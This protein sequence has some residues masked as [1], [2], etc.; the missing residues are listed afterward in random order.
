MKKLCFSILAVLFVLPT[1]FLLA[2]TLVRADSMDGMTID[3]ADVP[4]SNI[5]YTRTDGRIQVTIKGT[6]K[7]DPEN[8]Q[9]GI[10]L[11]K[12]WNNQLVI[13]YQ[14]ITK[15]GIS[16]PTL[17]QEWWNSPRWNKCTVDAS[18]YSFTCATDPEDDFNYGAYAFQIGAENGFLWKNW[19]AFIVPQAF[20]IVSPTLV[21]TTKNTDPLTANVLGGTAIQVTG[22]FSADLHNKAITYPGI[23]WGKRTSLP[24]DQEKVADL[25]KT[26]SLDKLVNPDTGAFSATIPD[27][28]PGTYVLG[29]GYKNTRQVWVSSFLEVEVSGES[30][31]NVYH[32]LPVST[33]ENPL[34]S[35]T[36]G[37]WA[38]P[39]VVIDPPVGAGDYQLHL[40]YA[41]PI[42]AGDVRYQC[43]LS[44][45]EEGTI[46]PKVTVPAGTTGERHIKNENKFTGLAAGPYCLGMKYTPRT[47]LGDLATGQVK[48]N[49]PKGTYFLK[50]FSVGGFPLPVGA[51]LDTTANGYGCQTSGLDNTTYCLLAPLPGVGDG[52]GKLD[53]SKGMGDY[54]N[55][56]IKLIMGII[57]VLSVLMIV[58]G[59]IEYMST[60]QMGEKEGAKD[61]ITNALMG[62]LLALA[63]YLILNTINPN[64]VNLSVVVE[65]S[66]LAVDEDEY[67]YQ[68]AEVAESNQTHVEGKTQK[69][70]SD[71]ASCAA[72]CTKYRKAPNE[73]FY[74]GTASGVMPAG[75]A[76]LIQAPLVSRKCINC[77]ASPEVISA[78]QK[79]EPTINSMMASGEIPKRKYT[80]TVN[81]AYRP[82]VDQIRVMC[83]D[84]GKKETEKHE[85]QAVGIQHTIE[86]SIAFPATSNHG[87][88]TAVDLGFLWDGKP[89]V[90]C[91]SKGYSA[92]SEGTIEKIMDRVGFQRLNGESWHFELGGGTN[93]CKFPN[94]KE[95]RLCTTHDKR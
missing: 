6:L 95:P 27:L 63:S 4:K 40:G 34:G 68:A 73:F 56:I 81:S 54:I 47:A 28:A 93:T 31:Q 39:E 69:L 77:S 33:G 87:V 17:K 22:T 13:H 90:N 32:L 48:V 85:W 44:D 70:C 51:T 55:I 42:A 58:V 88:G 72:L 82:V 11:Y 20:N 43:F 66:R 71:T 24:D 1:L 26:V 30:A 61:R 8:D 15:P 59:G 50:I 65:Q 49:P 74:D 62:L 60:V 75:N 84:S 7:G 12:K 18:D 25:S 89:A 23:F 64:L 5:T 9:T 52:T 78:L 3:G 21:G 83:T 2:P 57:G 38:D 10:G 37:F 79:L 67:A 36:P 76:Q 14:R 29:L 92:R 86:G 41:K 46:G 53:V 35:T 16:L 80:F 91:N 19:T 94:C 45:T